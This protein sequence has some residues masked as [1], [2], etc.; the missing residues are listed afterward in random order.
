MTINGVTYEATPFSFLD[1]S[2][3]EQLGGS[4]DKI[5]ERPFSTLCA[6]VALRTHTSFNTAAYMIEQHLSEGGSMDEIASD[7]AKSV[8][9]AGFIQGA[10]AKAPENAEK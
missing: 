4:I 5:E 6:Y 1:I 3:M 2:R 10:K 7:L 9:S 8:E